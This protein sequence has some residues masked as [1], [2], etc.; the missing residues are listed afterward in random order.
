MMNRKYRQN[1][2]LWA[3]EKVDALLLIIPGENFEQRKMIAEDNKQEQKWWHEVIEKT[4][5]GLKD[6]HWII[7]Q[8]KGYI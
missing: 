3:H 7:G 4:T 2:K 5:E 1:Y 6:G 8:V